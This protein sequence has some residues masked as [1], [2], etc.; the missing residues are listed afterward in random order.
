MGLKISIIN[1][2]TIKGFVEDWANLVTSEYFAWK[3][4]KQRSN[5]GV[6]DRKI[7][8]DCTY[9]WLKLDYEWLKDIILKI[10]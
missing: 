9:V 3:M 7:D 6:S 1:A 2:A 4:A 5:S 8:S 10:E